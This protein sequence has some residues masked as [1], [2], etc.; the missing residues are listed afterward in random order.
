M[1]ERPAPE[2]D[3]IRIVRNSLGHK[4]LLDREFDSKFKM[5][6]ACVIELGGTAE[7]IERLGKL[8]M[9]ALEIAP[10]AKNTYEEVL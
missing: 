4:S 1:L 6:M 2:L 5:M 10:A 8:R 3:T 7:Q 9:K